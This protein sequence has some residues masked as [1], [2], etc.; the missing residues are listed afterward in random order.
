LERT[1]N[2]AMKVFLL[3][4]PRA[5]R[6]AFQGSG[7]RWA[8][9]ILLVVFF[10]GMFMLP[11]G[12]IPGNSITFQAK[13]YSVASYASLLLL[14]A[15]T[16]LSLTLQVKAWRSRQRAGNIAGSA[17][18]SGFGVVTGIFSSMFA[19]ATCGACVGAVF[20]FLGFTTIIFLVTYR[21]YILIGA[22]LLLFLSI[23]LSARK[24]NRGCEVC[25]VKLS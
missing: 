12:L 2:N 9:I 20:G 1:P 10:A 24:I 23:Y 14:A 15:S 5:V 8:F 13:I 22:V 19:S 4:I 16:A 17:T 6:I 7:Y 21:W 25:V 18:A 11:V 3:E